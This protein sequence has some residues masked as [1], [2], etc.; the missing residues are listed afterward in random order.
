MSQQAAGSRLREGGRE[1]WEEGGKEAQ[2]RL[3]RSVLAP[4]S[5][6]T[7]VDAG[8]LPGFNTWQ[9][10]ILPRAPTAASYSTA[11]ALLHLQ[12]CFW[13]TWDRGD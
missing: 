7:V 5:N 3:G 2:P 6:R 10:R 4:H 1:G 8:A 11:R 9:P 12:L 13:R